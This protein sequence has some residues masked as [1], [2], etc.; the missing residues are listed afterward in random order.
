MVLMSD[1][2]EYGPSLRRR[3]ERRGISLD[4]LAAA[5][6]VSVDLWEG[7]E[8]NDF[9]RWPSGVFARAFMRDYARTV[10]LDPD[11][12]V[13]EFCRQFPTGDRRAARIVRAQ[14][15][16]IGHRPEGPEIDPLPA[17]RD[18]RRRQQDQPPPP[19]QSIYAPRAVAAA[20]DALC[21][22]GIAVIGR[23]SGAGFLTSIGVTAL[24]YFTAGTIGAGAS[25]GMRVV[26]ALRQRAPSLFTSRRAVSA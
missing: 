3:R 24:I 20:I 8:R 10:G 11:A 1:P 2:D 19:V 6:K 25:P 16:L 14:A 22:T 9:S 5:T 23:L 13:D 18:R 15:E 12:V 21:V 4:E 7:M 17:G 26:Q